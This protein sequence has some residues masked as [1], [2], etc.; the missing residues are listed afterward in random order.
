MNVFECLMLICH[1]QLIFA[2]AI[3]KITTFFFLVEPPAPPAPPVPIVEP[4]KN[5]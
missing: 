2:C 3:L 1:P 4:G 5:F